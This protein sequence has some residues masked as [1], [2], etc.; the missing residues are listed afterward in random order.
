MKFTRES[1]KEY[2]AEMYPASVVTWLNEATDRA[3]NIF[4]KIKTCENC[5]FYSY[6]S[7]MKDNYCGNIECSFNQV[8]V[9]KD[10]GCKKF[11]SKK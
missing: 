2:N 1:Q 9:E 3:F 5:L 8:P 4:E 10:D 6:D 11:E 7:L